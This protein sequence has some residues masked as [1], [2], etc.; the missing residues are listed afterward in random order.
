MDLDSYLHNHPCLRLFSSSDQEAV[1]NL[2]GKSPM[3]VGGIELLYDRSPDYQA[4]LQ[5]QGEKLQTILGEEEER[6]RLVYSFSTA[7][8]WIH[9]K[10]ESCAYI[11][12]F[13]TDQSRKAAMI[14][15]K[16]Y[17]EF[18]SVLKSDSNYDSPKYVLTA[19]LKKNKEAFLNFVGSQKDFGF[20]YD[21]LSELNMINVYKQWP[22]GGRSPIQTQ[23]ASKEDEL[24]LLNFLNERERDK[25]FGSNFEVPNNDWNLR[26]KTWPGYFI[27]NFLIQKNVDGKIIACTLPWDPSFAK[28]MTV[29]KAPFL[30]R[31]IFRALNAVGFSMPTVGESLKTLYMTHLNIDTNI[32]EAL[33]VQSFLH[34]LFKHHRK[35]HMIS[36]ADEARLVDRLRGFIYQKVGVMLYTVALTNE[37]PL[38]TES[39]RV[40]FE[41]GLV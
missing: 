12:D 39:K 17:A 5:C 33:S 15:R 34:Y 6:L 28:R 36:F 40:G 10:L 18:L 41:M 14:W 13:R 2:A 37:T 29:T 31:F 7:K 22:W 27:E 20:R 23:R 9:G 32:D 3:K 8:R 19:I 35:Y 21:F 26:E 16:Y 38:L 11:G 4:L 1:L 30:M 25:I 24:A